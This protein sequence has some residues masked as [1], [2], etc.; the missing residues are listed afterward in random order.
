VEVARGAVRDQPWGLTLG[1]F[2]QR[3][4]T[5]ELT[6]VDGATR[7][8]LVI[9]DGLLVAGTS[10]RS[11]PSLLERAA[12]TFDLANATYVLDNEIT[13]LRRDQGAA[14]DLREV[15]FTGARR[16]LDDDRL[17]AE[18]RQ[19][20][21][22]FSLGPGGAA[23]LPRYGIEAPAVIAGSLRDGASVAELEI[24]H[25]QIDRRA[26]Q[27]LLYALVSCG[28]ARGLLPARAP[29]PPPDV[30]RTTTPNSARTT[31]P[32]SAR[33]TTPNSA[34]TTTPNS[35]RTTTPNSARTTTPNSARTITPSRATPVPPEA[36][37]RTT[38]P[39]SA[40]TITPARTF[41]PGGSRTTTPDSARTAT[42][43]SARTTTPETARTTTPETARTATG[44]E[45]GPVLLA[46]IPTVNVARNPTPPGGRAPTP[47][48][49]RTRTPQDG[50]SPTLAGA[51]TT[52]TRDAVPLV[53]SQ[54]DDL[55][56]RTSTRREPSLFDSGPPTVRTPLPPREPVEPAAKPSAKRAP[57]ALPDDYAKPPRTG[58]S[59][60]DEQR[61]KPAGRTGPSSR[62]TPSH[63]VRIIAPDDEATY[64]AALAADRA[65]RLLEAHEYVEA[66]KEA[67]A[68][69][70]LV[71]ESFDYQALHAWATFCGSRDKPAV[72]DATRKLLEKA[73]HRADAPHEVRLLLGRLE[74]TVGRE[75]EALRHFR[76]VIEREPG[77]AEAAAQI[78]ELEAQLEA[79]ARR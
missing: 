2:A 13:Q 59:S 35:A 73:S 55:E 57:I 44:N 39:N 50:R 25:P 9:E 61:A 49:A 46:R 6:I 56:A 65:R 16:Y 20:G 77:H 29:T 15:I 5:G 18:L 66:Q 17:H 47:S 64:R 41:T 32:N 58:V 74:R 40:R 4:T 52:T 60:P 63:G 76:A 28:A 38:T 68:A 12:R 33:T 71:P 42:P 36:L 34:R 11:A 1:A 22:R 19:L 23:E 45:S 43:D 72:A 10:T 31:T 24:A 67:L 8:L 70:R 62:A 69:T 53:T 48:D 7:V 54:D 27:A 79:F 21:T 78:R 14:V 3:A 26:I 75:R 37:P 30:S 51:R